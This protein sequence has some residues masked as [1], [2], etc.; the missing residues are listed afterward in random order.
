MGLYKRVKGKEP[1]EEQNEEE[2]IEQPIE[3]NEESFNPVRLI[4]LIGVIELQN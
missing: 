1:E 4:E 3:Q 2:P